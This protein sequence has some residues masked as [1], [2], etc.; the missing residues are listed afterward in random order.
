MT[1]KHFVSRINK[2]LK[3]INNFSGVTEFSIYESNVFLIMKQSKFEILEV[4]TKSEF[5]NK[6]YRF[7]K[8]IKVKLGV[9]CIRENTHEKVHT[10]NFK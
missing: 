6:L 4:P 9:W 3:L 5:D 8:Y 7:V 1:C 10:E 2:L